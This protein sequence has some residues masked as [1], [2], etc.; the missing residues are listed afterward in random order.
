M[1]PCLYD[2]LLQHKAI[3]K[4]TFKTLH[5]EVSY[6]YKVQFTNSHILDWQI[7]AVSAVNLPQGNSLHSMVYE[8]VKIIKAGT[9]K[10]A[11]FPV[12]AVFLISATNFFSWNCIPQNKNWRKKYKRRFFKRKKYPWKISYLHLKRRNLP[13]NTYTKEWCSIK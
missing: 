2:A 11:S 12:L 8:N 3:I 10:L 1:H 5:K 9:K 7:L 6:W 4:D 13:F